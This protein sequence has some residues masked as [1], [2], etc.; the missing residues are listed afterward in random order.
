MLDN[1]E[2]ISQPQPAQSDP[3]PTPLPDSGQTLTI[4]PQTV[5]ID[6]VTRIEGHLGI[7]VRV[8]SVGGVQQVVEA[9]SSGTSFRG[10]EKILVNRHPWDAVPITQR[11]CGVCPVSHGLAASMTVEAATGVTAPANARIMRNLVLGANYLQSHIL[12]F[13]HLAVLDYIVGPDMAPWQ[14]HWQSDLRID[15]DTTAI[16]VGHYV[17]ALEMRRKG[18]ELGAVYG[19][20]LPHPSS[21]VPGGFTA[22]PSAARN[23]T[24][25]AYLNELIAFIQETYLPDVELLGTVYDDYFDIGVGAGNLLAYG[26]FDQN[27]SGSVKL[28][29][30]GRAVAGSTTIQPVDVNAITEYVKYSWYNQSTDNLPPA[31]GNTVPKCPKVGAYSWLKAPRYTA[32]PYEV[33]ALARMWVNGDYQSGISVM[34]RHLARAH[35]A[36][37]VAQAMVTWIGQLVPGAAVFTNNTPPTSGSAYGLTE[38][39]RGALG[40]WLQISGGKISRYQ[41]ITPTCWNASPR[42]TA[43]VRGPIEQALLGTP[44]QDISQPVEVL[45]VVHSFDPCLSCAVHVMRA[46]DKVAVVVGT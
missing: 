1:L 13:Y 30:R 35:E 22:Q 4:V 36:L 40:H 31:N 10:F 34:D 45:R 39:P 15:P 8:D 37:K 19:G 2:A 29:A 24:C 32:Q 21:Y 9:W 23:A 25:I 42:D 38:A 11:I 46:D 20:R 16:L 7:K 14:P 33:G 17:T 43:G 5:T 18:H 44:V 27:A 28:L 41:V 26:V 6:P 3:A 12:H